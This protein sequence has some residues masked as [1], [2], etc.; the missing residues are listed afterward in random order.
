MADITPAILSDRRHRGTVSE[1]T[2]IKMLQYDPPAAGSES[3]AQY[4]HG[5][6]LLEQAQRSWIPVW[7]PF[8]RRRGTA[9]I[10]ATR[11]ARIVEVR[12]A[13]WEHQSLYGSIRMGAPSRPPWW[14]RLHS[15]WLDVWE[16]ERVAS[17]RLWLRLWCE[18][19]GIW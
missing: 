19:V 15:R 14:R 16:S 7:R 17:L 12:L 8:L 4:D 3:R 1:P 10:K 2:T 9:L 6:R 13:D 18:R 5:A 11:V